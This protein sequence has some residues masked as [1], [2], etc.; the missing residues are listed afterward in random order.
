MLKLRQPAA[1]KTL[2]YSQALERIGSF[3]LLILIA[4][5]LTQHY[6][7]DDHS[8]FE[9]VGSFGALSLAGYLVG[10]FLSDRLLGYRKSIVLGCCLLTVGYILLG[11]QKL[12]YLYAGLSFACVGNALFMP[13]LSGFAGDFFYERDPR[14]T[15]AFIWI[16]LSMNVGALVAALIATL[17]LS[18]Y[19]WHLTFYFSAA[20][21]ATAAI[22][23]I[24]GKGSFENRG[25]SPRAYLFKEKNT[26]VALSFAIIL[27]LLFTANYLLQHV[28][29]NT[30]LLYILAISVLTALL[31]ASFYQSQVKR[32]RLIRLIFLIIFS[33]IF[34]AICA[35][36][37]LT[38]PLFIN[39]AVG[40]HY[41]RFEITAPIYFALNA[42]LV[43]VFCPI[44]ASTW[45]KLYKKNNE[46]T[47]GTKIALSLLSLGVAMTVLTVG[48]LHPS[49][50]LH[51]NAAW[52]FAAFAFF[53]LGESLLYPTGLALL[54]ALAPKKW[55]GLLIALW[56]MSVGMGYLI[57]T[58][59]AQLASLP[60]HPISLGA[61]ETVYAKAFSHYAILA[62]AAGAT[63]LILVPILKRV[64]PIH[65]QG[66]SEQ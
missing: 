26:Q 44:L 18:F 17:G 9:L 46:P 58:K 20:A 47:P 49:D 40:M 31:I 50:D 16:Y 43:A 45:R 34:W 3:L 25:L 60:D 65:L 22:V 15:R 66:T 23:F 1:L 14:R 27:A 5:F 24:F 33:T 6:H 52:V 41:D 57:A 56:F 35:Q 61:Q 21:S 53:A 29:L 51:V 32:Y 12:H 42:L 59:L 36:E 54:T 38:V 13:S 48:S 28:N 39:R 19:G 62:Y 30:V 4:T 8:T 63:L 64:V 37:Y 10:G 7:M 11:F 55:R 2:L